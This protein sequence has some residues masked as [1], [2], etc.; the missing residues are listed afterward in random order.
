MGSIYRVYIFNFHD[1]TADGFFE[2]FKTADYNISNSSDA[3]ILGL[4]YDLRI[5]CAIVLPLLLVGSLHLTYTINKK[6]T[7]LSILNLILILLIGL[8][9]VFFKEQ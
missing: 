7:A 4:R 8:F 3:F 9:A 5:A 6:L 2:Y 1:F